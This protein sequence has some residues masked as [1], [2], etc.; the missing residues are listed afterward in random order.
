[1]QVPVAVPTYLNPVAPPA[2]PE[3]SLATALNG[4]AQIDVALPQADAKVWVEG[5]P[6][7][8]GSGTRRSFVSPA[9]EPG[10]KYSY[11][12]TV[13]WME[14]GQEL[15]AERTVRVAPDQRSFADFTKVN[16]RTVSRAN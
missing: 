10:Y 13:S 8:E 9:L 16:Q 4:R 14:N 3:M 2:T 6:I 15:R 11:Q 12:V 7:A 1:V 5:T